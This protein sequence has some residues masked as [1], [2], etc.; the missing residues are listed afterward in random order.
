MNKTKWILL[1]LIA[2]AGILIIFAL[3]PKSGAATS[4]QLLE[5]YRTALASQDLKALQDISLPTNTSAQLQE[6]LDKFC[7]LAPD[8]IQFEVSAD[9]ISTV[10]IRV[11]L[12]TEQAGTAVQDEFYMQKQ[13]DRWYLAFNHQK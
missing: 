5:Q 3:M 13:E 11:H 1:G 2:L 12:H 10:V 7:G 9:N 8:K 4:E 6:R